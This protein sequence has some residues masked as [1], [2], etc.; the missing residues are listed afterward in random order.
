MVP[1]ALNASMQQKIDNLCTVFKQHS[2][3]IVWDDFESA[4]GIE[5]TEITPLLS[6][7]DRKQL[8]DFLYRLRHGKTKVIITSCCSET[9]LSTTECLRLPLN[10]LQGEECWEYCNAVVRDLGLTL[11]RN[12]STYFDLIEKLNG[13]PLAIRAVLLKLEKTSAAT[14]LKALEQNLSDS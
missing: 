6:N 4:S 2:F 5:G 13:H 11:D 12:D 8:K 10:G 9:W 1:N 14:L 7:D 3:I